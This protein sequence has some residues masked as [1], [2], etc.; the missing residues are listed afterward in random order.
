MKYLLSLFGTKPAGKDT[1]CFVDKEQGLYLYLQPMDDGSGRVA[2]LLLSSFP[3][4]R[5]FPVLG[6]TID[7]SVRKTP[8]GIGIGS[9]KEDVIRAYHKPV[10]DQKSDKNGGRGLIADNHDDD[11]SHVSVGDSSYLYSCL[12]SPKQGCDNDQRATQIGF[13]E[14]KVIWMRLSN[15]E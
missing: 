7:P 13:S 9:S 6:T 3:N 5:H 14:D 8:E 11:L 15:S 1:Y 10:F 2:D 12:L 4:C